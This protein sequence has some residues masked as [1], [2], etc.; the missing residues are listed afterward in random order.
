MKCVCRHQDFDLLT[1][2]GVVDAVQKKWTSGDSNS[3]DAAV[4]LKIWT[5]KC[6]KLSRGRCNSNSNSNSKSIVVV[7]QC[8]LCC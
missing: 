2:V 4:S 5:Q 8:V 6:G 7:V 3:L 1:G